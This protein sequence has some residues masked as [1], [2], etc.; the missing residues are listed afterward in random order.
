MNEED[1]Y[2][3]YFR[4]E[5]LDQGEISYDIPTEQKLSSPENIPCGYDPMGQIELEGRAYQNISEGNL[6]GWVVITNWIIFGS[7]GLYMFFW[8]LYELSSLANSVLKNGLTINNFMLFVILL[9]ALFCSVL[10]FSILW[11]GTIKKLYKKRK[12]HRI[13]PNPARHR[14]TDL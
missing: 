4:D 1:K 7:P 5:E 9:F 12:K 8:S 14:G 10:I 3:K 11:R 6:R 13:N 2:R